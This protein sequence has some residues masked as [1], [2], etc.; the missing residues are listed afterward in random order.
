MGSGKF[1]LMG[2]GGITGALYFYFLALSEG[3][4]A[5]VTLVTYTWPVGFMLVADWLAGRGL[6]SCRQPGI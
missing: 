5:K 2:V 4:P 3:D 1:W 6:R